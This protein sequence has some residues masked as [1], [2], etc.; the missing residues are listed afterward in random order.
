MW[1]ASEGTKQRTR[2]RQGRRDRGSPSSRRFRCPQPW[3]QARPLQASLVG[4]RLGARES[5][6]PKGSDLE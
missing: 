4:S 2:F 3:D 1:T 5:R 6:Q